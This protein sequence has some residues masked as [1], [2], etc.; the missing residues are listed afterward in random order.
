MN[1]VAFYLLL[2]AYVIV[3]FFMIYLYINIIVMKGQIKNIID[4]KFLVMDDSPNIDD[5]VNDAKNIVIEFID[6]TEY[7]VYYDKWGRKIMQPVN[8]TSPEFLKDKIDGVE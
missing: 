6:G 8:S 4:K 3:V 7:S 1:Q 2:V 5:I